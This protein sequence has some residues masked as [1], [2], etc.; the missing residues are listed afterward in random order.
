MAERRNR[1]LVATDHARQNVE[2][3]SDGPVKEQKQ[4]YPWRSPLAKRVYRDTTKF[5]SRQ[6]V[7]IEY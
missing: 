7:S 4:G 2:K 1:S 5:A 3:D 6:T